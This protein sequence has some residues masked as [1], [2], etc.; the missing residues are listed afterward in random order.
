[1]KIKL[2]KLKH[3]HNL[4]KVAYDIFLCFVL[5]LQCLI[6]KLFDPI[7]KS[8]RDAEWHTV[9][10]SITLNFKMVKKTGYILE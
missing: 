3:C 6:C 8:K 9:D 4:V 2:N 7:A 10:H 5:D 1:M